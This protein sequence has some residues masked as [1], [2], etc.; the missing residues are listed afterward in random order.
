MSCLVVKMGA[1]GAFPCLQRAGH[2]DGALWRLSH[3]REKSASRLFPT[4]E[5]S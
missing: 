1:G 4:G 3:F 2:E 5:S